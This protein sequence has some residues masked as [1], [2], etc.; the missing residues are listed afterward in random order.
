MGNTLHYLT[1]RNE[2]GGGALGLNIWE[3]GLHRT[4]RS[5]MD[6]I[7]LKDMGKWVTSNLHLWLIFTRSDPPKEI[8]KWLS[9]ILFT[10]HAIMRSCDNT[11]TCTFRTCVC[12]RILP[13]IIWCLLITYLI[14]LLIF[15]ISWR[16]VLLLRRYSTF[17]NLERFRA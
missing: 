1:S 3:G 6:Y 13:K 16:F 11:C 14:I 2:V 12:A 8:S 4:Y 9:S 5:R 10:L 17:Y 7:W 15:R